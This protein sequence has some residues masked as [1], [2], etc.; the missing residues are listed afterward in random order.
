MNWMNIYRLLQPHPL[1]ILLPSMTYLVKIQNPMAYQ[2]GGVH[3]FERKGAFLKTASCKPK[4]L[5]QQLIQTKDI[6]H[7]KH[8]YSQSKLRFRRKK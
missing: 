8:G 4:S 2:W 5:E 7:R 3:V 6:E 1:K